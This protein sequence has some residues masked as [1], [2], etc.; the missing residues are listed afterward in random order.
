MKIV[1]F[2]FFVLVY[3]FF[4]QCQDSLGA[5]ILENEDNDVT[6]IKIPQ[7]IW[8]MALKPTPVLKSPVTIVV[9]INVPQDDDDQFE[10][11]A[12]ETVPEND[13]VEETPVNEEGAEEPSS[14][15]E[16]DPP[17]NSPGIPTLPQ[18]PNLPDQQGPGNNDVTGQVTRFPCSCVSRQCGCCTGSVLE[19]FRTKAC[20]NVTFV[21]EEFV[22]DVKLSINNSTVVRQKVSASDPPPICFNPRR[23][24]FVE[25][26]M[27]L[28]NIRMQNRNAFACM[29]IN[30]NIA[31]FQIF[32]NSFR[33]F[34]FGA[35]G[36]QT[37][38]KPRP[39]K[40]GPKPIN[41]FGNNG[42]VAEGGFI[43]NAAGAV[44]GVNGNNIL[45]GVA[46]GVFGGGSND[47]GPLDA[48]GDAVGDFLDGRKMD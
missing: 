15:V 41:L 6:E 32:S 12:E 25:V 7:K 40:S 28:S 4:L 24:P 3:A 14:P 2:N 8:K 17:V 33:C 35:S 44:F 20:G 34:S 5:S 47:A 19:R 45:G 13:V 22:F 18:L 31:G 11:D 26:C 10:E 16:A 36:L 23:V 21:P 9:P 29:N 46:E 27:E 48:I 30:A 39:V 42:G 38:L 37:G 43:E 1:I